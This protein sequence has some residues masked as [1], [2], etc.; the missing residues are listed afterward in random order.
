MVAKEVLK[1]YDEAANKSEMIQ[2]LADMEECSKQDIIELLQTNGREIPE[3]R[4]RGR[5]KKKDVTTVNNSLP[6]GVRE[7]LTEKL[8]RIDQR[9]K[10]LEPYKRELKQLENQYKEIANFLCN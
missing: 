3:D 7:A 6:D 4:K 9:I 2:I 8:E 10:E 1:R 5:K